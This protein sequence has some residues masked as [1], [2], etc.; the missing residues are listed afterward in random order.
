[1]GV[2]YLSNEQRKIAAQ[3]AVEARQRRAQVIGQLRRGE[4]SFQDVLSSDDDAIL[5]MPVSQLISSLPRIGKARTR[6]AMSDLHI[7]PSRRVG[8]LGRKQRQAL[9]EFEKERREQ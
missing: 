1:M 2:P 9:L 7:S 8:G 3:K 4:A 5:R 6:K